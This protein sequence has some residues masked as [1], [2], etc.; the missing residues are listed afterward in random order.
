MKKI[1]LMLKIED[2]L[3]A[4]TWITYGSFYDCICLMVCVC[5]CP[6]HM[7]LGFPGIPSKFLVFLWE[8]SYCRTPFFSPL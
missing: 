8:S 5:L 1:T 6:T 4:K 7:C 3:T 2:F